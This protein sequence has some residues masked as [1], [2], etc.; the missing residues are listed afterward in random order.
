MR[1]RPA[2]AE[3]C[4]VGYGRRA[5]TL[6]RRSDSGSVNGKGEGC[7]HEREDTENEQQTVVDRW[8]GD[9]TLRGAIRDLVGASPVDDCLCLAPSAGRGEHAVWVYLYGHR[10]NAALSKLVGGAP[11]H[12]ATRPDAEPG[13]RSA[14]WH[15]DGRFA[16]LS[17]TRLLF[18]SASA[19]QR[20]D[21]GHGHYGLQPGHPNGYRNTLALA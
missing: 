12:F 4:G 5:R 1:E 3:A 14:Q 6:D 8:V 9:G 11:V 2:K 21:A 7:G 20:P 13:D 16:D 19:G 17:L 15:A 10:R 18:S